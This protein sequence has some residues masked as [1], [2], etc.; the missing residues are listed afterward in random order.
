M[1]SQK[2]FSIN[3]NKMK[4]FLSTKWHWFLLVVAIVVVGVYS[5]THLGPTRAGGNAAPV[6]SDIPN[7]LIPTGEPFTVISLDNYVNDPDGSDKDITWTTTGNTELSVKINEITREATIEIPRGDWVGVENIVFRATDQPGDYDEDEAVF[8]V[9]Y[10]IVSGIPDQT[11]N[12]GESFSDINLDN[13]VTSL[14]FSDDTMTWYI[15]GNRDITVN[16]DEKNRIVSLSYDLNFSGSETITFTAIDPNEYS[17]EDSAVF[18]VNQSSEPPVVS[19]SNQLILLGNDFDVIS[20]DASVDDRDTDDSNI[21]WTITKQGE[22]CTAAFNEEERFI[23]ISCPSDWVGTDMITFRATDPEGNYDEQEVTLERVSVI[24]FSDVTADSITVNYDPDLIDS[25]NS[26]QVQRYG[27]LTLDLTSVATTAITDTGLTDN[28]EYTYVTSLYYS[29]GGISGFTN[30]ITTTTLAAVPTEPTTAPALDS[31]TI[32]A[33]QFSNDTNGSSGYYFVNLDTDTNSGWITTNEWKDTGLSCGNSY[34]YQIKYRNSLGVE[35]VPYD[36]KVAAGNCA[37]V[38]TGAPLPSASSGKI[39]P[40]PSAD[41][42][43]KVAPTSE[44]QSTSRSIT[45]LDILVKD[46]LAMEDKLIKS[47]IATIPPASG[48][49][50]L[51]N[52]TIEKIIKI[53][54]LKTES[55]KDE[56]SSGSSGGSLPLSV[57]AKPVEGVASVPAVD[58][59]KTVQQLAVLPPIVSSLSIGTYGEQV[60]ALKERLKVYGFTPSNG[61][62]IQ[63]FDSNTQEVVKD[64][65]KAVGINPVGLVGPRTKKALNGQEFISNPQYMFKNSL[66]PGDYNQDVRQL[67]IR[68]QDQG[69][70]PYNIQPTGYYG[71]NTKRAVQILQQ[72]CGLAVTGIVDQLILDKL[73]TLTN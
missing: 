29:N 72:V 54:Q 17:H 44:P 38:T 37:T 50:V 57:T 68:L 8:S 43:S 9:K 62:T 26:W 48:G 67:Q 39:Q 14:D 71:P 15:S 52:P 2:I 53:S 31:I 33:V 69:Y 56:I 66:K 60:E 58:A 40:F 5:V 35:T 21:T 45:G 46:K 3:K 65:Q 7:Q 34:N 55:I 27:E 20:L 25:V 28:T 12:N 49:G 16:L 13:Y 47:E 51:V 73:N 42:S 36:I 61:Q 41:I 32:T 19:M 10:P 24:S 64:F 70:F 23:R 18:T 63:Q 59:I 1:K 11:I 30:A 4:I 6:V 22:N